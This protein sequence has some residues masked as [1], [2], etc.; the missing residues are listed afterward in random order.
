MKKLGCCIEN[1]T[2][3]DVWYRVL[4]LFPAVLV[5]AAC[6]NLGMD[7]QQLVQRAKGYLDEQNF[8][9]ATIELKNALQE[10]P[11][12]AEARYLL[13]SI[14]L[15]YGD[16]R[17]AEKE[18]RRAARAGWK[19]DEAYI[20]LARALLGYNSLE[21]LIDDTE[22]KESYPLT[23]RADLLALRALAEAG[24]EELDLARRT[25]AEA[26]SLKP[27]AFQVLKTTILL[28]L[29]SG[30][31]AEAMKTLATALNKYPDNQELLLISA[32][33]ELQS[34]NIKPALEVYRQVIKLDP[35][36]YISVYG[37]RA[38]IGLAQLQIQSR[39]LEGAE[40][41]IRLLRKRNSKDPYTDYLGG[42]LAF[43][44]GEYDLAEQR[45]LKVLKLA[46]E[47]NPTRLLFGAV[48]YAQKDYEQAAYF[49]SKYV[50]AVPGNFIARKLLGRTYLLLG[51]H[52]EARAVLQPVL[53]E[54]PDDAELHALIGI[55]MLQGGNTAAGIK[56]L[57]EAI[58]VDPDSIAVRA[59]LARAYI[60]TGDTGHAIQE[61]KTILA[62]G[63]N[64]KSTES[65]LIITHLRAGE[66]AD[67]INRV[68]DMLAV[69][70]QDP[71]ILVLAGNV[72]AASGD[73]EEARRYLEETLRIKPDFPQATIA[74]ARVEELDG[75]MD[76]AVVLYQ[77]LVTSDVESALP[78]LALARIAEQQG[79]TQEMLE[80]LE[81]AREKA[82]EDIKPRMFLAEFYLREKQPEK[83][84]LLVEEAIKIKPGMPELLALQGKVLLA[85]QRYE[86]ALS[87]LSGLVI[88]VPDS[89]LARTLLGQSYLLMGQEEDARKQL[90]FALERQPYFVAALVALAKLEM[91]SGNFDQALEFTRRIEQV[92][93]DL[94]LGYELAGDVWMEKQDYA[95]ARKAYTRAW[96]R[97]QKSELAIKLSETATRSGKPGMAIILLQDWLNEHT[98]DVMA[99]QFLGTAY[100]IMGQHNKAIEEYEK[101]LAIEPNNLVVAN[102]LA[103]V[104]AL[105]KNI[106][107]AL[108][109]SGRA[110]QYNSD[111][112]GIQDTYGWILV[113]AG[114]VEKGRSLLTQAM[115]QLSDNPEVRYHY[116]VAL[117]K[118]GDKAE[119]NKLLNQ[120]LKSDRQFEG[121]KEAQAILEK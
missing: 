8:N 10:N 27:E 112:P 69:Y 94:P 90:G 64:P 49:L 20:G 62:K 85:E 116:A 70:P 54:S 7:D 118:T 2:K 93:P 58:E 72:F 80:W 83:A 103:W 104:Y 106:P 1:P 77:S 23:A 71:V 82:P 89:P 5:L 57:E 25:L 87:L 115:E 28:Q 75:N 48:N 78:L 36:G 110:Y 12:N 108:E 19:E 39:D 38:L 67:A 109:L 63:G 79:N 107:K 101:A 81:R 50:T 52:D 66:Y 9:A 34:K 30:Q 18:F 35:P 13:G 99:R 22:V 73:K 117:L 95:A 65:L 68:L 113:Q 41:T 21:R 53:E 44:K 120:L 111:N 43:A 97:K 42:V 16:Y 37:R 3:A 26:V 11:D 74:L 51:Q 59:E 76:D 45:F 86:E 92:K 100:Q 47:H 6:G 55:S 32:T 121:R 84:G 119:A 31:S 15:D 46:P 40:A 114:Q 105:T 60:A 24:L 96:D 91:H 29:V 61:L 14:M 98:G 33:I 17:T 88:R 4:L 56:G 102:N